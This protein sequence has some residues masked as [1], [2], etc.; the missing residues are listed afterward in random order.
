MKPKLI[1]RIVRRKSGLVESRVFEHSPISIG[2]AVENALHLDGPSLAPRQGQI[3]FTSSFVEYIDF[4]PLAAVTL[5]GVPVRTGAS[6]E[7]REGS[8][9]QLGSCWLC[10]EIERPP[11]SDE[12]RLIDI[13][14]LLN[15][16][17]ASA[18]IER[19]ILPRANSRGRA[20]SALAPLVDR[21]VKLADVI[22]EV[23]IHLRAVAGPAE[24]RRF[25]TSILRTSWNA[26]ELAE[27]L[28]DP[29]GPDTRLVEMKWSLL[30]LAQ[31]S[32][33]H[34]GTVGQ[35]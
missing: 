20:D 9:L 2:R 33:P 10:A 8:V 21:A 28:L 30:R 18:G 31:A 15:G 25:D 26:Q 19:W 22:A 14:T 7:L 4:E 6:V 34:T 23:I 27:W 35:S 1:I 13:A 3:A 12:D 17:L 5:D 16:A 29:D 24:I 11:S 32:T